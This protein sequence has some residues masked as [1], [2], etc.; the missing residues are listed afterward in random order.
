MAHLFPQVAFT[1][2]INTPLEKAIHQVLL[3]NN[4]RGYVSNQQAAKLKAEFNLSD[5]ELYFAMLPFAACYAYPTVSKFY[6]GAIV[7]DL[8]GNFFFGANQE[9]E[10]MFMQ[11]TVHAEQCA[12]NHAFVSGAKGIKAIIVNYSPCGQCRQFINEVN[13]AKDLKIFLPQ[14]PD[15]AP[16]SYYLPDSFGPDDLDV[17]VRLFDDNNHASYF[18]GQ[19]REAV[20]AQVQQE[21]VH[22]YSPYSNSHCFVVASTADDRHF[23]GRYIENAA[24]SPSFSPILSALTLARLYGVDG[25]KE[26][27]RLYIEEDTRTQLPLDAIGKFFAENYGLEL[28]YQAK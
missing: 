4:L 22:S 17:S 3:D 27:K 25:T 7:E 5:K 15:G 2:S 16:L 19:S 10:G 1:N 26:I 13:T 23:V 9:W 12:I 28:T 24:Y 20:V 21:A 8:D 18:P 11:F 6:V 14:I